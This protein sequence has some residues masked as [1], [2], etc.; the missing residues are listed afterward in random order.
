MSWPRERRRAVVQQVFGQ[1]PLHVVLADDQ[2]RSREFPTQGA[3]DPFADRV[4][5]PLGGGEGEVAG[6]PAVR[7]PA[8]A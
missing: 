1:H 3:D 2:Q 5:E 4:L 8:E 6:G 7:G